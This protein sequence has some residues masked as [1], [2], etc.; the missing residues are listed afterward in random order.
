MPSL[1]QDIEEIFLV[2][3]GGGHHDAALGLSKQEG[4]QA[5]FAVALHI[6]TE[7]TGR[8]HLHQRGEQSTIADIV[9][10]GH[11]SAVNQHAHRLVQLYFKVEVKMRRR[12][13]T[14]TVHGHQIF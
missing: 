14:H 5:H 7:A 6:K 10:T 9:G 2:G 3:L 1:C 4:V 12:A 13:V 8:A 11:Q